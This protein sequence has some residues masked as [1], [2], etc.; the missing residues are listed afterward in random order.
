M[1]SARILGPIVILMSIVMVVSILSCGG[2]G[3]GAQLDGTW[4]LT[5]IPDEANPVGDG[6]YTIIFSGSTDALQTDYYSGDGVIGGVRYKINISR[7]WTIDDD[8]YDY[9]LFLSQGDEKIA[10]DSI[11]FYGILHGFTSASG[12]YIGQEEYKDYGTGSFGT[13]KQ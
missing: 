13:M 3:G 9:Y 4:T 2:G 11:K 5:T 8:G 1:K 10:E 12:Q 7:K 6:T